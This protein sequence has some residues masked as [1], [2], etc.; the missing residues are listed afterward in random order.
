[1]GVLA[2][3]PFIF[4]QMLK[5]GCTVNYA[6]R[7]S[8]ALL[9][10]LS[11]MIVTSGLSLIIDIL[12]FTRRNNLDGSIIFEDSIIVVVSHMIFCAFLTAL[13]LKTYMLANL[14]AL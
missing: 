11:I 10:T 3:V 1:M 7:I 8:K 2:I 12:Y 6:K 4:G 9:I 14:T 13:M 5:A